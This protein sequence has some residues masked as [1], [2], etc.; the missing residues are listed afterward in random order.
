MA[1]VTWMPTSHVPLCAHRIFANRFV[2]FRRSWILFRPLYALYDYNLIFTNAVL[3]LVAV[4]GRVF[5]VLVFT[6]I[7]FPRLDVSPMP[8][9]DGNLYTLD[10]GFASYIAMLRMD[11]RYNNPVN[12]VFFEILLTRLRQVRFLS[13]R[14]AVLAT[15]ARHSQALDV[16]QGEMKDESLARWAS[17]WLLPML[18]V[19][20]ASTA[21]RRWRVAFPLV[22]R[23]RQK[24]RW[25]CV[26]RWQMLR[27]LFFNPSL[28][29]LRRHGHR[30]E[31]VARLPPATV[32]APA[33]V[34]SPVNEMTQL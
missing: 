8:G 33:S 3:G 16:V 21:R 11:H 27:L 15:P 28:V 13:R 7:Y 26:T 23:W 19:E 29:Q 31:G 10:A 1:R 18:S 6:L 4:I 20:G 32:H 14:W 30:H 17:P 24:Q 2:F 12:V 34:G 9:P 5:M 22:L 25:R